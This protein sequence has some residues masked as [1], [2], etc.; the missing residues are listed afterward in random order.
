M[1][2]RYD[3]IRHDCP[4]PSTSH[5]PRFGAPHQ[6]LAHWRC[7][8]CGQRWRYEAGFLSFN[9]F[10][11]ERIGRSTRKWRKAEARRLAQREEPTP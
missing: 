10:L 8:E 11:W 6:V 4:L 9:R 2:L 5:L 1:S 7:P 3:D